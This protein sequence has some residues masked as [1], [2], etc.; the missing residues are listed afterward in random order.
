MTVEQQEKKELSELCY[1]IYKK[2]N[3]S[4]EASKRVRIC[5]LEG[6]NWLRGSVIASE[7]Q[8]WNAAKFLDVFII[9]NN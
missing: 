8:E 9:N 6:L 2:F 1:E 5:A 3:D 7:S 4:S